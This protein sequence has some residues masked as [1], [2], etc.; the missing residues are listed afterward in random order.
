MFSH[1]STT[2]ITRL[3]KWLLMQGEMLL[4]N[5]YRLDMYYSTSRR[6]NLSTITS[7]VGPD[8]NYQDT[9]ADWICIKVNFMNS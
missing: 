5:K 6:G 8:V 7:A 1:S 2:S 4:D 3:I 9:V